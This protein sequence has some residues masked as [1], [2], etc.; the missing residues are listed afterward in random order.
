MVDRC[1]FLS[2]MTKFIKV[3]ELK[4]RPP[5]P[6]RVSGHAEHVPMNRQEAMCTS[7]FFSVLDF[8]VMVLM[9]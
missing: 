3:E 4:V 5:L 6:G 7:K 2:A 1:D 9:E 8:N